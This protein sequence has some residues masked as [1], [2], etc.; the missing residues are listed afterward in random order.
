M[1][2]SNFLVRVSCMTYN[3]ASFIEDAMKGFCMQITGFPFV[4]VIIDDASTDGE[5]GVIR[6]FL[7][8]S[9]DFR[10]SVSYDQETDYGQIAFA[11]HKTNRNCYFAV[12]LLKE[13]HYQQ[14]K[15][16][17]PYYKKWYRTKYVT[18]CEGDDYWLDP[19]KLQKQVGFLENHEDY[20]FVGTNIMVDIE[21]TLQKERPIFSSGVVEDDFLL[22][23]DVFEDAIGGP[24]A[25][26]VSVMY[27]RELLGPYAKYA[28]GDILLESLLAKQSKY[29]CYQGYASVYRKGV[30]VSSSQ[31][32][33]NR[34]LRYN[35]YIV[36]SRR[37]QNQLF[38][39][40]CNWQTDELEDRGTYLLLIY[41]IR[42]MKWKEAISHKESLKSDMYRNKTYSRFLYGPISCVFL[43]IALKIKH[44]E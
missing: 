22:V 10:S 18:L 13:N 1:E 36:K 14:N 8:D 37:L 44:H 15:S 24:V 34:A 12:I 25:R 23:G 29:A 42:K 39:D 41:A 16:K 5:Q 32:D 28:I 27:K 30:G 4:C 35:D 20:G 26:T 43:N 38:P 11:P 33:L 2:E 7:D 3:Q 9:F 17:Y 6:R 19:M 40:Y 31:N 21:G